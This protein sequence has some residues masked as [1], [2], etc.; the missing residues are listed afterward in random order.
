MS[1]ALHRGFEAGNYD[2]SYVSQS[3]AVA[4][5]KRRQKVYSEAYEA[6]YILGFFDSYENH[7]IPEIYQED[8][9]SLEKQYGDRMRKAGIAV[10][11]R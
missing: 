7:E 1:S 8:V 4:K 6:A 3:L 9:I 10:E 5:R 11:K 2:N